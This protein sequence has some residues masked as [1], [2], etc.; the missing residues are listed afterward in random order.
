MPNH[1]AE[2]FR[3]KMVEPIRLPKREEREAAMKKAGYNLFSLPAEEVFIDLLTDSGTGAMSQHQ[4]AAIMEGDESYAGACS[5]YHLKESIQKIFGFPYFVPTHQGRAAENILAALLV[6]ASSA[7]PSNMHFDTTE[8]NIRAR[9]GRPTNLVN[10]KAFEV[11]LRAPF[12]GNMDLR[13]WKNS[14]RRPGQKTSPL[15]QS[16]LPTTRAAGNRF[17]TR[18]S[19]AFRKFITSTTSPSSS[20]PA[21]SRKTAT[22]SNSVKKGLRARA[23]CRLQQDLCPGRRRLDELQERRHRQHRRVPGHARRETLPDSLQRT[24]PARRLSDLWRP[25]GARPGSVGGGFDGRVG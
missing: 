23:L 3:I 17:L 10:D 11:G 7:I 22:S 21:G 5:F 18:T 14:S 12:K 24:D 1:P 13:S 16:Q 25:G 2:P 8:A 4:W 9:G 20:M 19:K 6:K 15:V